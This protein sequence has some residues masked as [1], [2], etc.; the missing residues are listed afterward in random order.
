ME[1]EDGKADRERKLLQR[2]ANRSN[3][4]DTNALFI[5][6]A[7]PRRHKW[8][9]GGEKRYCWDENR[10]SSERGAQRSSR[11]IEPLDSGFGFA[12]PD[13]FWIWIF[14]GESKKNWKEIII[15]RQQP[16]S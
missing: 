14:T 4:I 12:F 5:V 15:V 6:D 10:N 8:K 11:C 16:F 9:R 7:A 13:R 3:A 2:R 1:W